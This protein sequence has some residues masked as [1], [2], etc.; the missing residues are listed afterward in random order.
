M[1]ILII[2]LIITI[3]FFIL[4]FL[5]FIEGKSLVSSP[6]KKDSSNKNIV[7]S[8]QHNNHIK[9]TETSSSDKDSSNK[10]IAV[11]F[12]HNNH[13]KITKESLTYVQE[14]KK[15]LLSGIS[16]L[17]FDLDIKFT[18]AHGNLIEYSRGKLIQHDDDIDIR[19][20]IGDFEKWRKFS[21]S[22]LSRYL[23]KYNL[24]F[25]ERFHDAKAQI[26]NGIQCRL[27]RFKNEKNMKTFKMDIHCD[28][29]CNIV[30]HELWNIYDIDFSKVQKV[31]YLGV[32]TY[33][34]IDNDLQYI[35]KKQFG[36]NYLIPNKQDAID[37]F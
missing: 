14:Y 29:V 22:C 30:S 21:E 37:S 27:I 8:F 20:D 10:N 12:Q 2:L 7:A 25:D 19:F 4:T 31:F 5:T 15:Q 11:S 28:L 34:P 18:I 13:I 6:E 1:K 32:E 35:L 24:Y 16:K 36:E 9:I 17:L 3:L 26:H 23:Q 33:V